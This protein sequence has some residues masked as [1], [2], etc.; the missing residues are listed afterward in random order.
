MRG[1]KKKNY[2]STNADHERDGKRVKKGEKH[3]DAIPSKREKHEIRKGKK[4]GEKNLTI[5]KK[6]S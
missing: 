3:K 5:K 1:E 6:Y 4:I 2:S